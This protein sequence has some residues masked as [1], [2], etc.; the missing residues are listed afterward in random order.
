[1]SSAGRTWVR[2]CDADRALEALR[3]L[4]RRLGRT[5]ST[6]EINAAHDCPSEGY[7]RN[8]FG[9]VRHAFALAGLQRRMPGAQRTHGRRTGERHKILP[10]D[11]AK[12]QQI[13]ERIKA[14]WRRSA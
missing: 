5:P 14:Y 1:M 10:I 4:A 8:R 6:S 7:F 11:P 13:T 3:G 12:A 9:T 2:R